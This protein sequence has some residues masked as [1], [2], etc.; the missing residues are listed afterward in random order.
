MRDFAL[1]IAV[2]VLLAIVGVFGASGTEWGQGV[3]DAFL[4][5]LVAIFP[6]LAES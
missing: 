3:I 4:A 5:L 1:L 6:F 2:L